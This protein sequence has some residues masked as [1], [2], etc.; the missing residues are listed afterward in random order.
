MRISTNMMYETTSSQL[1]DLQARLMRTQQQISTGRKILSP[2]DDPVASA[3]AFDISQSQS[4]NQQYATNRKEVQ[5]SLQAEE[6]TLQSVTSLLQDMKTT[7]INAGNAS[8]DSTQRKYL[9]TD[10]SN[11]FQQLLGLANSRDGNGNYLFAGFQTTAQPFA[12]SAT[13]ATYN[14]DQGQRLLQVGAARQLAVGDSGASI[15]ETIKTGNGTFVTQPAAANTGAGIIGPGSVVDATAL[16]GHNYSVTFNVTG[17]VTTYDIVDNT[18]S[19]TLSAG[20]AYTSGQSITFD[21]LQFDIKG[22]PANGDNF[23]VTPSANQSIFTTLTDLIAAVSAGGSGDAFQAKL[24][25]ALNLANNNLDNALDN[26]LTVRASVGS[27]MREIDAL[28]NAGADTDLQYSQSLADLQE[29]DYAKAI[30][31]LTLQQTTLTAAQQSFTRIAN[32]SLF[33]F[34]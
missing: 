21:G 1:S 28:D 14:G 7:V 32:L 4:V 16:T 11:Q 22:A 3:K 27:R 23:T 2:S 29:L 8:L 15:F 10:L 34:L 17:G 13:G 20:N 25:N 31:S 19:T 33:N 12:Q 24:T 26:V 9:A 30:S 18:T 6:G 5:T